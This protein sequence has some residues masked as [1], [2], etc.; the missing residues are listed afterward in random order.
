MARVILITIRALGEEC[1]GISRD[2]S[3][4]LTPSRQADLHQTQRLIANFSWCKQ[5]LVHGRHSK[6]TN[7]E[8]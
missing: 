8:Y 2:E 5:Q 4:F 6:K 1:L 7:F 3:Q